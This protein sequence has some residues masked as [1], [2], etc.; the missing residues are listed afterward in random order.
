MTASRLYVIVASCSI[1]TL[2]LCFQLWMVNLFPTLVIALYL[3]FPF[4]TSPSQKSGSLYIWLIWNAIYMVWNES[5]CMVRF[6][7][8][9][10]LL[11]FTETVYLIW[12][13]SLSQCGLTACSCKQM[14]ISYSNFLPVAKNMSVLCIK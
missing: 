12:S 8:R 2:T 4:I 6:D 7:C 1:Y 14:L 13:D 5:G 11:F 10:R 3:Y 9:S